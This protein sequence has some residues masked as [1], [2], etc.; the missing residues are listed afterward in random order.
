MSRPSQIRSPESSSY[1]GSPKDGSNQK[2]G[3]GTSVPGKTKEAIRK[4]GRALI[5]PF[6][7][8]HVVIKLTS[9]RRRWTDVFPRGPTGNLI[10]QHHFHNGVSPVMP[11]LEIVHEGESSTPSGSYTHASD[12]T[13]RTR[14]HRNSASRQPSETNAGAGSK[15]S[16]L[17]GATGEQEW[18]P[19][20]TTGVDWKSLTIPACLPLTTD[21]F[22]DDRSLQLDYLVSDYS[23]LP[24]DVNADYSQ[25]RAV[26]RRPL[27]TKEVF[28][29]LVSQRLAQGFQLV[30]RSQT[31]KASQKVPSSTLTRGATNTADLETF[32]E[33][34]L[35]I[36][37][38]FHRIKLQG[39][40]ITVTRYRPRHPYPSINV[41]Y[42]YRFGSSG[43]DEFEQA[44]AEFTTEKLE[45][46]NWNY[47]D[48]YICTRGD[49]D[50]AL[51]EVCLI[52]FLIK[53]YFVNDGYD[54]FNFITAIKVLEIPD[55][56]STNP[57]G[58]WKTRRTNG[59]RKL[60]SKG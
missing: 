3:S 28:V 43:Y 53:I 47:L 7:P 45:N 9:N 52:N 22:P 31:E 54:L 60:L 35:S 46:Y 4:P 36:G 21:Y 30:V 29:E 44:A 20:L 34:L 37:R 49:P 51:N 1:G 59:F 27:N 42:Q 11:K 2:G 39:S 6:D 16:L 25:Q 24:D 23:L 57:P 19:A 50:F 58:L 17:W 33:Y 26:Y 12:Q 48:H 5:N 40:T 55:V 15:T 10:Q 38:I 18:T 8:S 56:H 13:G 32:E 14:Q 41:T